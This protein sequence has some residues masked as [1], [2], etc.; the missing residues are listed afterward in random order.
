V[1]GIGLRASGHIPLQLTVAQAVDAGISSIEHIDYAYKAGVKDEGTIAADFAAG[2]IDRA[3]AY[4]RIDAGFDPSTARAAYAELARK[5]VSVTPTLNGSRITDWLDSEDHSHDAYLAYI[6][7]KLRKTYDWRIQRANRAT[8]AEVEYRHQHFAHL[9]AIL[10]LLQQAGV[11]IMAG[12]D[13]GFLNSFDYPGIG[14]HDELSLFVKSGLTASQALAS[15]TRAGPAWFGL[16]DQYGGVSTGK[17]ADLVLLDQD[18]L[19]DIQATRAIRAVVLR[20]RLLDRENAA[21]DDAV[22]AGDARQ[23]C[24]MECRALDVASFEQ[25][26]DLDYAIAGLALSGAALMQGWRR[27][28]LSDKWTPMRGAG[29]PPR[30]SGQV[31]RGAL[32]REHLVDLLRRG[33]Y[34]LV[35]FIFHFQMPSLLEVSRSIYNSIFLRRTVTIFGFITAD[36]ALPPICIFQSQVSVGSMAPRKREDRHSSSAVLGDCGQMWGKGHLDPRRKSAS[37]RYWAM[38]IA[39]YPH[40][41]DAESSGITS[42]ALQRI[43]YRVDS[44]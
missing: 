26:P 40:L 38:R 10:P 11:T 14:L 33:L 13:A 8:P 4:R 12:T 31:N 20:G 25:V 21:V 42:S 3:E 6:G 36:M 1:H 28:N 16:A 22:A 5:G 23:G 29:L 27:R 37:V 9:A 34:H 2:R 30:P 15:A 19:K 39:K 17:V 44:A 41:G 24:A 43:E 18:P 7:P 35:F 32:R